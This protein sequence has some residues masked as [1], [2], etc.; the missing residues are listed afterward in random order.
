MKWVTL[1]I[2]DC[3]DSFSFELSESRGINLSTSSYGGLGICNGAIIT[4][5]YD[6][7]AGGDTFFDGNRN[8]PVDGAYRFTGTWEDDANTQYRFAA[9]LEVV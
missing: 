8:L 3:S 6:D 2:E 5:A 9:P 7:S 4:H 1:N